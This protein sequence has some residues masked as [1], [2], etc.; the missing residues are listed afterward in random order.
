LKVPAPVVKAKPKTFDL[1]LEV[2][3]KAGRAKVDWPDRV[4]PQDYPQTDAR[5]WASTLG[6]SINGHR[7]ARLELP[8]DP[9][10]ARGVLSHLAK[11]EHGSHGEIVS[12]TGELPAE[13][14]ADVAA[15]KPLVLRLYVPDDAASAGGLTVYGVATGAYPFNPTLTLHTEGHLPADLGAKPDEPAIVDS[16]LSRQTWILTAGDA[17]RAEPTRW[18]YTTSA[19]AQGWTDAGFDDAAWQSGPAGFGTSHTPAIAVKTRWESP[20]IWLRTVVELPAIAASD[21][22]ILHIFHDEDCEVFINGKPLFS[23]RGYISS[24]QDVV[25]EDA[26]KSLFRRG[27]NTIAVSCKQ[28]G[29]G[30]GIDV[31]LKLIK[32]E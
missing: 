20:A 30:Q 11:V 2:A 10:D 23:A 31:G 9:A 17:P 8:D 19:P 12:L 24:Y 3:S 6:I 13:A 22:L 14:I 28:T 26:Q 18:R 7:V 25:L 4:N 27:S 15:G 21:T 29:G 16:M 32:S 1:L 5:K